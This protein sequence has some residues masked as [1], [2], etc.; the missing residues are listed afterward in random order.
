MSWLLTPK[1]H[2]E[3]YGN[4]ILHFIFRHFIH[5]CADLELFEDVGVALTDILQRPNKFSL[6]YFYSFIKA[7]WKV[8]T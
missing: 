4:R 5:G 7:V 6:I 1:Y 8:P 3:I 2:R